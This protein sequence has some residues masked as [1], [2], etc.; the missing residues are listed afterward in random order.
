MLVAFCLLMVLF[1]KQVSD[2]L[3]VVVFCYLL[4]FKFM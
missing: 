3:V 2:L 4:E 1:L